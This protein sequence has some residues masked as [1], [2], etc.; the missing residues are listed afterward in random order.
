MP[1]RVAIDPV[2]FDPLPREVQRV[3][4][5]AV[6]QAAPVRC[7]LRGGNVTEHAVVAQAVAASVSA[8]LFRL[9]LQDLVAEPHARA[10]AV[11]S[12][13][14]AAEVAGAAVLLDAADHLA[15]DA[16]SAAALR[17]R[18]AAHS[19][20]VVL[21]T[22]GPSRWDISPPDTVVVTHDD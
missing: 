15:P 6:E 9:A 19:G 13:L 22:S 16:A 17:Q 8:P 11:L 10:R 3:V 7:E 2:A 4:S 12:L 21:S 5:A 20:L 18:L 14:D 1:R